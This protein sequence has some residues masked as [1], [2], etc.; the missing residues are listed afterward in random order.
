MDT[1]SVPR[2]VP[3]WPLRQP[4]QSPQPQQLRRYRPFLAATTL[5]AAVA[6]TALVQAGPAAADTPTGPPP[7]TVL[8]Q[9]ADNG[10]GDIFISPFG[11]TSTYENGP[12]IIDNQGNVI[13][14]HPVPAGQE[15]SDF[16]TQTY[17]GQPVL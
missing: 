15:A 9:G 5:A 10:N 3:R 12:E 11:D 2:R 13:W 4:M 1:R 17:D 6:G 7:V 14:F 16:R 8:T